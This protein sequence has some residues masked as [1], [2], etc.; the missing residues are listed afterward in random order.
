MSSRNA[1]LVLRGSIAFLFLGYL[2]SK[3]CRSRDVRV[4]ALAPPASA[5]SDQGRGAGAPKGLGSSSC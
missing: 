5:G 1:T 3:A 2:S 4:R